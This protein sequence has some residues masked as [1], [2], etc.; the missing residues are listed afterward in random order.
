MAPN[1]LR[2]AL[3][4]TKFHPLCIVDKQYL[5]FANFLVPKNKNTKCSHR[6]AVHNTLVQKNSLQ[7]VDEIDILSN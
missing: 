2:T 1:G 4:I 3:S 7:N 6:K 5:N